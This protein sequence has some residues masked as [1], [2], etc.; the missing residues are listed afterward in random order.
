M[1]TDPSTPEVTDDLVQGHRT[2]LALLDRIAA[3][4]DGQWR[5][6]AV[7]AA[8][9]EVLDHAVREEMSLYPA[10]RRLL[11]DG[12]RLADQGIEEHEQLERIAKDLDAVG[13][14]HPAFAGLVRGLATALRRHVEREEATL[15]ARLPAAGPQPAP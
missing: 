5:G 9:A 7:G 4:G 11:P 8:V 2:A 10:V 14:D 6:A 15:F 13:P 1:S 12:D 3:S